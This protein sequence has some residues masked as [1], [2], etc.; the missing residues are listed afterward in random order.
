M[1]SLMLIISLL[2][3]A[4]ACMLHHQSLCKTLHVFTV[5]HCWR[6]CGAIQVDDLHAGNQRLK[7]TFPLC[8]QCLYLVCSMRHV[9]MATTDLQ[10]AGLTRAADFMQANSYGVHGHNNCGACQ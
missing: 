7:F 8:T 4:I 10:Q 9:L 6:F 3:F 2:R 1:L 5:S